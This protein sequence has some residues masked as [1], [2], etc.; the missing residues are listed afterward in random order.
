MMTGVAIGIYKDLNEA[1]EYFVKESKT[2]T[3][4]AEKVEVYK[5]YYE[6]YK[7]VY[8]AVR[9]IVEGI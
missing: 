1:K 3:P 5:K 9:P 6:A 4:D 2:Y 8:N 7:N